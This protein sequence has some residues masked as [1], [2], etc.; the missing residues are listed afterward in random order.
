MPSIN[1]VNSDLIAL[2]DEDS[3]EFLSKYRWYKHPQGYAFTVIDGQ[4]V[5]MHRLIMKAKK[6]QYIDHS[7]RCKMDNRKINLRFCNM[8]QNCQN[9]PIISTN[10]TGYKGIKFDK[11]RNHWIARIHVNY[12]EHYLGSFQTKEEAARAYDIAALHFFGEFSY[13][14]FKDELCLVQ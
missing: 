3:F 9:R 1:I 8:S 12:K 5:L 14:N 10:S 4:V 11:R 7:N 2:V 6:G 13:T